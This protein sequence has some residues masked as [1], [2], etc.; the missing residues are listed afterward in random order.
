[1]NDDF[2]ERHLLGDIL[3]RVSRSF[4]LTMAVLPAGVSKQVGL[5]YLFAR[6]ADSIA[7]TGQVDRSARVMC[8][9]Q[10]KSQFI[11]DYLNWD[12]IGGVQTMMAPLQSSPGERALLEQLESCFRLYHSLEYQDQHEIRQ[13][14]PTLISGMEMDLTVFPGESEEQVTALPTMADLD[15]YM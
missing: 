8:L 2:S 4:Y 12:E 15:T 11:L 9:R 13:L 3:K 10:L 5:A 7:D 1:M 6:A 14:L